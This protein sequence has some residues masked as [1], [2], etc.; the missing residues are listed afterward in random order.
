MATIGQQLLSPESGWRRYNG[1]GTGIEFIGTW[2]THTHALYYNGDNIYTT[3]LNARA[4]FRFYGTKLRIIS[5]RD[6]TRGEVKIVIDGVEETFSQ[7][8][9]AMRQTLVYEKLGL[10]L[11]FHTVVMSLVTASFDV[12]AIDIDEDGYLLHSILG[13]PKTSLEEMQIGDYIPCKYTAPTSGQAGYFSE[14]GTCTASEISLSGS[15]TP[16]GLFYFIK[17]DKGLLIAD[18]VIQHSISWNTLNSAGF[19]EEQPSSIDISPLLISYQKTTLG[20]PITDYYEYTA[21]TTSSAHQ[22]ANLTI[23]KDEY[24]ITLQDEVIIEYDAFLTGFY[25]SAM[26]HFL[27]IIPYDSPLSRESY[28][29]SIEETSFFIQC[30]GSQPSQN[31]WHHMKHIIN[32]STETI[33]N[34]VDG[35]SY[36]FPQQGFGTYTLGSIGMLCIGVGSYNYAAQNKYRNITI[37]NANSEPV[38]VQFTDQMYLISSL[39]G[40]CTYADANGNARTSDQNLGGWPTNNEWDT[41]I[42]NSDLGGRITKGDDNVWHWSSLYS[43]TKDTPITSIGANTNRVYRGKDSNNKLLQIAGSAAN[44]TIGFRPVLKYIEPDG[45]SKQTTLWY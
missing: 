14:L 42:V 44:T 8:G 7:N 5:F 20:S 2:Q 1:P 31:V 16:N 33:E 19:I 11:G 4:S 9:S 28:Y 25:S 32:F 26:N 30:R 40:G 3:D 27:C 41:Y 45:S 39:S 23:K 18:R 15:A 13:A 38:L 24:L 29:G 34:F 10:E 6:P 21:R 43:W 17:A 12:D 22:G 35:S 37:K 36:T